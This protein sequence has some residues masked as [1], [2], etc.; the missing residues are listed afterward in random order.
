MPA[1]ITS[2]KIASKGDLVD[3]D[4]SGRSDP[5]NLI[6]TRRRIRRPARLGRS[7]TVSEGDGKDEAPTAADVL[8]ALDAEEMAEE[9]LGGG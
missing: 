3:H 6:D 9:H 7:R 5:S 4:R 8:G 2:G 1:K